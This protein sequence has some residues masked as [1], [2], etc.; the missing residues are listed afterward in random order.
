MEKATIQTIAREAGV[1]VGTVDRALNGRGRISEETRQRI[2]DIARQLHYRPNKAASALGR[3][4]KLRIFAITPETPHLFY[5]PIRDGIEDAAAEIRDLGA[6]VEQILCPV[7]TPEAQTTAL[8]QLTPDNCDGVVLCA[9]SGTAASAIDRLAERGIPAVTF[10]SDA[11]DSRRVFF[12]GAD[13]ARSGRM[14][15]ELMARMLGGQGKVGMLIG[16]FHSSA[17][18]KEGFLEALG[19]YPGVIATEDYPCSEDSAKTAAV[20]EDMLR[21]HPDIRGLFSNSA[22]GAAVSGE[23]MQAHCPHHRPVLIGYDM[24]APT[25]RY[26]KEGI[27]DAIIDQEP[28]RQSYNAVLLLYR[29]LAEK[30][31]PEQKRMEVRTHIVMRDN[32]DDHSMLLTPERS[33]LC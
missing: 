24:T 15:G 22:S 19:R 13:E 12:V 29:H 30:W 7:M 23:Y 16:E 14:A 33:I 6:A 27:V 20:I 5:D 32:A 31:T 9:A 28:R 8:D 25:A 10:N 1:S 17:A 4:K 21:K 26:L 11:P 2:L 3:Q 18:R